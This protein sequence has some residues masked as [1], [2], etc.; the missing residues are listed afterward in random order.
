M[1]PPK[2]QN[3]V[4]SKDRE[5]TNLEKEIAAL[6]LAQPAISTAHQISVAITAKDIET[7]REFL[8]F[9]KNKEEWDSKRAIQWQTHHPPH[10]HEIFTNWPE[11]ETARLKIRLLREDDVGNMFHILSNIVAMKYYG[12]RPHETPEYTREQYVNLQLL[13]FKYRDS[14]PLA[15]TLK[16]SGNFIGHVNVIGFDR[17]FQFTELA[18]ILDPE[19]WGRGFGTEAIGR[20]VQF[21]IG[22]M[23]LHKIRASVFKGNVGSKRVLEKLGFEQEGHLRD[24]AVID[25]AYE[26]EYIMAF[27]AK[28]RINGL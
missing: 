8:D 11:L 22:E 2:Q 4:P 14:A 24:N 5:T 9:R 10:V 13:R 25:G 27:I 26:D 18:Y 28:D 23:K 12:S 20:V 15:I 7:W 16:S 21:L 17:D 6:S 1:D 3:E 19:F